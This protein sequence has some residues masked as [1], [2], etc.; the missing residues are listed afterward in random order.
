MPAADQIVVLTVSHLRDGPRLH[1]LR[2]MVAFDRL[3][4]FK[5]NHAPSLA[6]QGRPHSGGMPTRDELRRN[7]RQ[8]R[9]GGFHQQHIDHHDD[10]HQTADHHKSTALGG[11][12]RQVVDR[13]DAPTAH[14]DRANTVEG[15]AVYRF[16]FLFDDGPSQGQA[17]ISGTVS[18]ELILRLKPADTGPRGWYLRT[19]WSGRRLSRAS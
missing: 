12:P 14:H 9:H 6:T 4:P 13:R 3:A 15:L 2:P 10:D 8:V 17:A 16:L 18:N 1:R 5:I 7:L 11:L 19:S